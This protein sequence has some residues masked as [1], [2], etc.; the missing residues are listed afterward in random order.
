MTSS[1]RKDIPV[2]AWAF[3]LV[4]VVPVFE[5]S[6]FRDRTRALL[7]VA[8]TLAFHASRCPTRSERNIIRKS[9]YEY[10]PVVIG[11]RLAST[12]S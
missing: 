10:F 3:H 1:T 4:A 11:A 7:S 8:T 6:S 9:G 12:A 2:L 5:L